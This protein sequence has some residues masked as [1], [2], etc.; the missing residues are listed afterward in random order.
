MAPKTD[1]TAPET[2]QETARRLT[3]EAIA[4]ARADLDAMPQVRAGTE[5]EREERD[6][7]QLKAVISPALA[8]A[9]AHAGA[10]E[11]LCEEARKVFEVRDDVVQAR[12]GQFSKSK[13]WLQLSVA[14]WIDS[15]TRGEHAFAFVPMRE[16]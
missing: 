7:E 10:V 16:H 14:E 15:E 6:A 3:D 13:P 2:V 8:A 1:V 11:Y 12:A 5:Q 9:G 4:Q